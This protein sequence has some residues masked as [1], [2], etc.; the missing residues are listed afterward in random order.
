MNKKRFI[1]NILLQGLLI[2]WVFGSWMLSYDEFR[3]WPICPT[4]LGIPAC[5]IILAAFII[6]LSLHL[7]KANKYY[8]YALASV[9]ISIAAYGTFFQIFGWIECPK[10]DAWTPMCFISLS[11]FS[12]ITIL[13]YIHSKL[14]NE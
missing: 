1:I 10:T 2:F 9:P 8:F 6:L 5:Y 3:N 7:S 12:S 13:K 14:I 4:L 11:M